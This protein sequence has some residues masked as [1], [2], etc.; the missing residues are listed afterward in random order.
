MT[1]EKKKSFKM[2]HLLFLMIG[3]I[4]FIS[5]LTYIVPAGEFAV[6]E[7]GTL[8][9]NNFTYQGF[10]TPVPIWRAFMLMLDGLRNSSLIT[11]LVMVSGAAIQVYL[12]SGVIDDFLNWSL[13]KL[14]DKGASILI[15]S[16]FALMV[17]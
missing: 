15:P 5:I 4:I 6:R 14:Q 1:E 10:Q 3:L 17:I 2:P 13:A 9:P 8:D 16:M 7:D 12:D 11:W